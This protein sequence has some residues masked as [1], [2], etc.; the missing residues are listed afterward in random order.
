MWFMDSIQAFL[1]ILFGYLQC[2][3][4]SRQGL[5]ALSNKDGAWYDV[6]CTRTKILNSPEGPRVRVRFR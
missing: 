4:T 2:G 5:E 1:P 6:D 3:M